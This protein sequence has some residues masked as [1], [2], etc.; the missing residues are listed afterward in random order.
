MN[1]ETTT[2]QATDAVRQ[3]VGHAETVQAGETLEAVHGRFAKHAFEFMAVLDGDK[4]AGLCARRQIGMVLGARFGFAINS[5]KPIRE[6]MLPVCT[7]ISTGESFPEILRKVFT[8]PDDVLFDDVLLVDESGAFVGVVFVRTL[9]RLQQS[10]LQQNIQELETKQIELNRKNEE[11]ENDLRLA[12]EVQLALLPQQYPQ[13][14]AGENNC[15]RFHHCYLPSGVVSGDFF[16][17]FAIN[18]HKVGVFICDVMG[19]GVRSAFVTAML[20]TLVQELGHLGEN[21]GELLTRVNCELKAILKQT[22]DLVYATGFYLI[23]DVQTG[24]IRYAKAGHPD[25]LCLSR[26][27]GVIAPLACPAPT[28]GAALGL[29]EGS[30]YGTA[31]GRVAPGDVLFFLTD[32]LCEIFNSD[33]EEFGETKLA[34]AIRNRAGQPLKELMGGVV[35][36]ALAFSANHR[37]EDDVCFLGMEIVRLENAAAK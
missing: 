15:L 6:L 21:P 7:R 19:H 22:G 12:S 1:P 14:P 2:Q 36:E 8:R 3:L 18:W 25:P 34:P 24:S 27:T 35:G 17:V 29:F 16:H 4:L 26:A 37:F 30:R 13:C 23:L 33:G 28:R 9:V 31:E 10:L 11:L 32:G 5:R 20:R